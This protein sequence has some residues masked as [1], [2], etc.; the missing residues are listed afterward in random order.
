MSKF[1]AGK[2]CAFSI[3]LNGAF[4]DI[5]L[6]FAAFC[7]FLTLGCVVMETKACAICIKMKGY[8]LVSKPENEKFLYFYSY[9]LSL[10]S[11][12]SALCSHQMYNPIKHIQGKTQTSALKLGIPTLFFLSAFHRFQ[13]PVASPNARS[14]FCM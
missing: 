1:F 3:N 10:F 14:D 7:P 9:I 12:F 4:L 2:I 6:F 5:T 13:P 11:P 8:K